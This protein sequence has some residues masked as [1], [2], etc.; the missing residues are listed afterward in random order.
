MTNLKIIS[1]SDMFRA[2]TIMCFTDLFVYLKIAQTFYHS[3][4]YHFM[5]VL[6]VLVLLSQDKVL[7]V[8]VYFHTFVSHCLKFHLEQ[9]AKES[10][11]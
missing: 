9:I 8:T 1:Y 5:T 7:L 11:I 3:K 10:S 2:C 4:Q 6:P